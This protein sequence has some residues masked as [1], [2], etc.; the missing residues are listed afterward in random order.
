MTTSIISVSETESKIQVNGAD[1]LTINS[2]GGIGG[3]R[4]INGGQLAGMRNKIINGKME[5]G[6]RGTFFVGVTAGV[7]TLDRWT[8]GVVGGGT[9]N[10]TQGVETTTESPEFTNSLRLSVSTADA[11]IAAGD[12]SLI[13]HAIEGYNTRDLV[14]RTF[15]IS[16]RVRSSKVGIHCVAFRSSGSDRSYIGEYTVNIANTW[17]T[18][19]ITVVGGI[20]AVGG[21]WNFTNGAGLFLA[22]I[23]ACGTNLQTVAGSWQTGNFIATSNQVNCLDTTGNIFAITGVQLEVGS[24]ATPFEHRLVSVELALCQRYCTAGSM[25]LHSHPVSSTTLGSYTIPLSL[26]VS[27]RAAPT[28]TLSSIT[29]NE[30]SVYSIY[31]STDTINVNWTFN[32]AGVASISFTYRAEAEL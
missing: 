22:F 11:S 28:T 7:Y 3:I 16:F 1:A 19:S 10:V 32:T 21:T 15:T 6:Q 25:Q 31:N 20:P 24:V 9:L 12:Y 5:L 4:S 26:P 30:G 18:K 27:M 2:A 13:T 14:G 23:L 29:S 8:A 17:E